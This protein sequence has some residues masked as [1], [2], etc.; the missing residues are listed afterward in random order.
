MVARAG[1]RDGDPPPSSRRAARLLASTVL[2]LL[3]GL[4]VSQ[5]LAYGIGF[6]SDPDDNVRELAM[7]VPGPAAALTPGLVRLIGAAMVAIAALLTLAAIMILRGRPLGTAILMVIG[8]IYLAVALL[9]AQAGSWWDVGFYGS[10]GVALIAMSGA[11]HRLGGWPG[12]T[13]A[14]T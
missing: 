10:A 4:L 7:V 9:A 3:V 14:P 8:A 2:I 6:V 11:V 13:G 12:R 5:S 1:R